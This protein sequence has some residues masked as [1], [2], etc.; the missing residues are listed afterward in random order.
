[1]EESPADGLK[2][3]TGGA[4]RRAELIQREVPRLALLIIVAI[5]AFFLT[6]AV[7]SSNRA[8]NRRDAA[9]W[10]QRGQ[11]QVRAGDVAHAVESLRRATIKDRDNPTYVPA[12]AQALALAG[13]QTEARGVLLALRETQPDNSVLNLQLARLAASRHD[14]TEALRYYHYSLY[15]PASSEDDELRR[16]VR[17]ELVEFLISEHL[18]SRAVSELLVLATDATPT[19]DFHVQLGALFARAGD[20]RHALEQY[21][22]ALQL[23]PT[24]VDALIG[25][26]ETAFA[27]QDYALARQYLHKVPASAPERVSDLRTL[28]DLALSSDPL[29]GRIGAT[30][31]RR[32]LLRATDYT[33]QRLNACA[34]VHNAGSD[35]SGGLVAEWQALRAR[36]RATPTPDSDMLEAAIDL[37][38]RTEQATTA[39]CPPATSMDRALL[40]MVRLHRGPNES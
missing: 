15:S 32:R 16:R 29:A 7:A 31:R 1:V 27:R 35:P 20:T 21:Q 33:W 4:T 39:S 17:L 9:E 30:E 12:L 25:A 6:R 23:A 18:S 13:R 19:A 5:G 28:V 38:E 2:N 22:E 40:L 10:F 26:G 11:A 8:M 3:A 36:L 14:A 24:S 34:A 37:I